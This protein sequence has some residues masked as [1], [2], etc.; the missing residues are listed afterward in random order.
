LTLDRQVCIPLLMCA[1]PAS[2]R[3]LS[4]AADLFYQRGIRAVGVDTV[5]AESAVAKMT[6]YKHFPS[7]DLLVVAVLEQQGKQWRDWLV[8]AVE[9]GA[10]AARDRLLVLFDILGEWF[11]TEGFRGDACL[12]AAIELRDHDH[13]AWQVVH[14][15]KAWLRGYIRGLVGEAGLAEPEC[16]AD[17]IFLLVEGAIVGAQIGVSARPAAAARCA[18]G[19]LVE[20]RAP[21]AARGVVEPKAPRGARAGRRGR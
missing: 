1:S 11:A 12:N 7:K 9:A 8:A 21:R 19:V 18:A 5:V 10:T 20:S 16:T 6:L 13:P 14:D 2:D 15:H 3:V 17:A 4:T